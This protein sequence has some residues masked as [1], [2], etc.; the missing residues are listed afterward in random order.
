VVSFAQFV[1]EKS[2]G[3]FDVTIAPV[4]DAWGFGATPNAGSVPNRSELEDLRGS[5]GFQQLKV[6]MDPP[7]LQKLNPLLRIDLSSIAKGHGVDRIVDRLAKLGFD[8]VFVEIG[9]EVRAVGSKGGDSWTVGIQV[10]DMIARDFDI[11]W[12]LA[13]DAPAAESMATSGDYRNY[14]EIDGVRYSHTIDPR[15]LRPVIH[16]LAS[17]SVLSDRCME[18]DAWATAL[19]VMGEKQGSQFAEQS[20]LSALFL[21]RDG[22]EF[23]RTGTGAFRSYTRMPGSAA[24]QADG[25]VKQSGNQTWAVLAITFVAFAVLLFA[26]AVGVIFSGKSISG[27]CGGIAGTKAEDGSVSCSL[28]SNPADACKELRDR[29]Q[30]KVG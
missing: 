16:H 4:V 18:S 27:S 2:G 7:S 30:E 13:G 17:V 19:N 21:V 25:D 24:E 15:T 1:S 11:A 8:D 28:C 10:P 29:M 6:R 12:E 22:G 5:I 3:A 20:G 23:W 26:M 9:G 14:V